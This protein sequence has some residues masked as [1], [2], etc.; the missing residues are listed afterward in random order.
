MKNKIIYLIRHSESHD[1][2]KLKTVNNKE[3]T[4]FT[5]QL[6]LSVRGEEKAKN[7][8]KL[9]EI[10]SIKEIWSSNMV[11]A[12]STAKYIAEENNIN[13]NIDERFKERVIGDISVD[14]EKFSEFWLGQLKNENLKLSNGESRLEVQ[15]RMYNGIMD[16]LNNT[17]E[18]SIGILTHGASMTFLL[19]KWCNLVYANK[20]KV[21]TLEFKGKQIINRVFNTPEVFKLT[22]S[23]NNELIDIENLE[24]NEKI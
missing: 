6:I 12:L 22:F 3:E 9:P 17:K 14:K 2:L 19:M 21:R 16:V 4:L 15:E 20:E 11:R 18:T 7:L 10:K 13:L 8:S 1:K 5:E 23:E 24:V